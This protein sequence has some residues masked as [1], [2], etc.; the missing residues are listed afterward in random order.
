[1]PEER[2]LATVLF[3]DIV[4][5]TTLAGQ[6]DPERIRAVFRRTFDHLR[7][8]IET[9][10]GTVEKF[11][12]DEVMAVFGVPIAHDDDAQRAVRCALAIR[13]ETAAFEPA[14]RLEL[15]LR[16][17][18][19]TGNVIASLDSGDQNL[20]TGQAVN[21]AARLRQAASPGEILVGELTKR[22][23]DRGV[24]YGEHRVI[25]A[26]NIGHLEAWPAEMIATATPEQDRGLPGLRA[27][28]I[29]RDGEMQLLT[30]AYRRLSGEQRAYLVTIFGQP[31]SGKSR[32][33]EE[34][35]AALGEARVRRGRCLPYGQAITFYPLQLILREDIGLV[36]NAS[37]ETALAML[38]QA[39]RDAFGDDED[40]DA[41]KRRVAVMIGLADAKEAL[42][43]VAEGEMAEELRWGVR[44]Y[45][46]R[47]AGSSPLVLVFEDI[48]WAE[49][50]LLELIEDLAEW[51]RAPLLILCLARPDLR[52]ARP[53]WGGG[54]TNATAI[55]LSPLTGDQ[56]RTL[57]AEL[58]ATDDLSEQ[59]Q[60][61]VVTRAEGNPLYVEEFL[62]TLMETGQ[63]A[64][65]A[66]R[67]LAVGG[68]EAL[69]VPPT[70]QGL[71]TARLDRVSP[72]V[73]ALLQ[74]ASL[75]GRLFSTSALAALAGEPPGPEQL[76]EAVR[77]DLLVE[78][79][80]RA[81]VGRGRVYRFKHV[82]IRDVAYST[83]PKAER[84]LL[85][86]R[87]GRW[88]ETA[89]GE[90]SAEL[91]DVLAFHAE[92]AYLLSRELD[93]EDAPDL[94]RR[95]FDLVV[96]AADR[97]RKRD[98]YPAATNLYDRSVRIAASIDASPQEQLHVN[99]Q[100]A[101]FHWLEEERDSW[102]PRFDELI[103]Q[104][105][106]VGPSETLANLLVFRA[107]SMMQ[108]D[109]DA[110]RTLYA[111]A[112]SV[113]RAV[114]D[115]E[116]IGWI[117]GLS[118][119]PAM[120][121]GDLDEAERVL[122]EATEYERAHAISR[123]R[124]ASLVRLAAL[125]RERAQF[126]AATAYLD[127]AAPL[128]EASRSRFK[129]LLRAGALFELANAVGDHA[130]AIVHG[131]EHLGVG[132]EIGYPGFIAGGCGALGEALLDA[133]DYERARA[134][135]E[136]SIELYGP[137]NRD[138]RPELLAHLAR[139]SLGLGHIADAG[140]RAEEAETIA[141]P[142]NAQA[143]VVVRTVAGMV[144]AQRGD[145]VGAEARFRE[146]I[147]GIATTQFDLE[148]AVARLQFARFLLERTRTAE[149]RDQLAAARSVFS[150]P[151]AFRRRDEIDGLLRQCDA[152]RA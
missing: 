147:E 60:S 83:L 137:D 76:R 130:Q 36:A 89:L 44:R 10:G 109:L 33:A 152:V 149:A 57:I 92:Q 99:G 30:D 125:K 3:A 19:N 143:L 48:H 22:L 126:S 54:A 75:P 65:H 94:G 31:G 145:S 148:T 35:L 115:A 81:P 34:F 138:E 40:A 78:S 68:V 123:G 128:V 29:G 71:I 59:L 101:I 108:R 114:G 116:T 127:E 47:R 151:L 16:I 129:R 6:H 69:E 73:K 63:I 58:L 86:D 107:M 72:E 133:G 98:D 85:H 119:V 103:E 102:Q 104:G 95:A 120:W 91:A 112:L 21:A 38:D 134:T 140:S 49:P 11:I 66:G 77:R 39:V 5:S 67:W 24:R 50:R 122:V 1:V 84:S 4:G 2:K 117:W 61:E 55:A 17:G 14:A 51:S 64:Q 100:S 26:K 62:R 132:E 45:F 146:A 113:A 42:A 124:A 110:S 41:V 13:D 150:D 27:P 97:A 139:A 43:D 79:D 135:L 8:V 106:R 90:R 82:L 7:G 32:L 9:H 52:E 56:T 131:T 46:E 70:L 121:I 93:A 18:V 15:A 141:L 23:T 105:R 142:W 118:R 96:A 53:N 25:E 80:E 74:R 144:A 28:L 20:V 136:R 37:R 87:Y 111:E 12:G 88:I